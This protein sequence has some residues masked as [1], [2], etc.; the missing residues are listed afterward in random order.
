MIIFLVS[1]FIQGVQTAILAAGKGPNW[2]SV[3]LSSEYDD[4]CSSKFFHRVALRFN[5]SA[6]GTDKKRRLDLVDP[7]LDARPC[8]VSAERM[9]RLPE[10]LFR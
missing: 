2:Q 3:K 8:L 6:I 4:F 1:K 5:R 7:K 9:M 10:G